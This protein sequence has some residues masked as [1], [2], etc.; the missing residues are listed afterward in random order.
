M[1]LGDHQVRREHPRH[2]T[3]EVT[4]RRGGEPDE[5]L[6]DYQLHRTQAARSGDDA[7]TR[8]ED[9][10]MRIAVSGGCLL[11]VAGRGDADALAEHPGGVA[12]AV[13]ADFPHRYLDGEVRLAQ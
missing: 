7:H 11:P 10:Q 8:I 12:S 2:E 1:R 13:P 5:S 9:A 4:V 6:P 3:D